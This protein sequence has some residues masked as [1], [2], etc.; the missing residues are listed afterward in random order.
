VFNIIGDIAGQH[1]TLMALVAKMPKCPVLAVGDLCDRGPS[2]SQVI[3]WFRDH[4]EHRVLMGNHEHMMLDSCR[5]SG[6]YVG[7]PWLYNGGH[8]TLESFGLHV[9]DDVLDW[10]ASLPLHYEDAETGL[11]VSHSFP[12]LANVRNACIGLAGDESILWSRIQPNRMPDRFQVAGHNSQWGLRRFAD[13]QG[14]YAISIDTSRDHVLTGLHWPS[15]TVYQQPVI[16]L[17]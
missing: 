16:D 14:D 15:R 17:G 5:P 8:K 3:S 9:P 2:S 1:S 4:P 11:F 13:S 7:D 6:Q 10:V 12:Y